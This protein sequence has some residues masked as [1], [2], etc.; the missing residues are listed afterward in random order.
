MDNA[1]RSSSHAVYNIKLHIVFVTK[2]RRKTLT[3]ELLAYLE[4]RGIA[5]LGA[6]LW[7][8]DWKPMMPE[9]QLRLLTERLDH[10]GKGI[11]L[12]HDTK[13]QTARMLPAFL[14]HLRRNGYRIVH[15]V[16]PPSPRPHS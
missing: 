9:Q 10:A 5:V 2:Y 4:T 7:A 8:S 15:L 16:P 14:Q 13:A 12:L 6:D 11:I 1:N 3:P